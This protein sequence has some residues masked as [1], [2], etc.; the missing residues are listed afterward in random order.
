[1]NTLTGQTDQSESQRLGAS[2]RA[3]TANTCL[4]ELGKPRF[5]RHGDD[6]RQSVKIKLGVR[7]MLADKARK[8]ASGD[9]VNCV[10]LRVHPPSNYPK[11]N[12]YELW[13]D[14]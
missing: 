6:G 2:D 1:M 3:A 11:L 14:R 13:K 7:D 12:N 9:G 5:G 4:Y 8:P 10:N